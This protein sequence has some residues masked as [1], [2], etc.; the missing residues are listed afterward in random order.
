MQDKCS[1]ATVHRLK[2]FSTCFWFQGQTQPHL[3]QMNTKKKRIE[4][5]SI[6][7][8]DTPCPI[9]TN[10]ITSF[11]LFNTCID[12]SCYLAEITAQGPAQ[13]SFRGCLNPSH[14]IT[15]RQRE[16]CPAAFSA[17]SLDH[18]SP[19]TTLSMQQ[20]E[21]VSPAVS[22]RRPPI[23]QQVCD[24]IFKLWSGMINKTMQTLPLM[25]YH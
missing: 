10:N 24:I 22:L 8:C 20:W 5:V 3:E 17:L 15:E 11:N 14:N 6:T 13:L 19:L 12:P 2:R 21:D 4:G 16:A 1:A 7:Q 18:P 25:I 23:Q 9:T